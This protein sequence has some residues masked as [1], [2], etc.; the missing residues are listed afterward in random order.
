MKLKLLSCATL[1]TLSSFCLASCGQDGSTA[2][3]MTET[4]ARTSMFRVIR[5]HAAAGSGVYFADDLGD[6][7]P[8]Q[9]V[10]I[11]DQ[12]PIPL[13]P[14]I[15]AGSITDASVTNAYTLGDSDG[16]PATKGSPVAPDDPDADWRVV[17]AKLDIDR[18]WT[19][20]VQVGRTITI[21]LSISGKDDSSA[22]LKGLESMDHA[23]VVLE[24]RNQIGD[25]EYAVARSGALLGEIDNGEIRFPALASEQSFVGALKNQHALNLAAKQSRKI[26]HVNR[27]VVQHG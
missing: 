27:G 18:E 2:S 15:V 9:E 4:A 7:L 3:A 14:G 20:Q 1:M 25:A 16:D 13:S 26:I 17:T 8:Q 23:V 5:T 24:T 11:D 10:Q 21:N 6:Y 12:D 22:F 19:S